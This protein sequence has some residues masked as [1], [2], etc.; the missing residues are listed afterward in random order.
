MCQMTNTV[1]S[2]ELFILDNANDFCCM[3]Y[4]TNQICDRYCSKFRPSNKIEIC[5]SDGN[6]PYAMVVNVRESLI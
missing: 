4:L 2:N 1:C 5:T 6:Q 3:I